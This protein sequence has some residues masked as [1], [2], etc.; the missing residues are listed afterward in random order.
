M[1]LQ[2]GHART[3]L[4]LAVAALLSLILAACGTPAPVPPAAAAQP[5]ATSTIAPAGAGKNLVVNGDAEAGPGTDGSSVAPDVPGWT[6]TGDL[7]AIAYDTASSGNY[8]TPS[9]PGPPDR[10]RNFFGGG[11]RAERSGATQTI[12]VSSEGPALDGGRESYTLSAWLG[13]FRGQDDQV[14]LTAQFLGAGG[15][16]LATASLPVVLDRDRG[17][18]TA[19]LLRTASGSVPAGTRRI[20]VDMEMIRKAGTANDGYADDVSLVL[21]PAG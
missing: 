4:T 9:D 3:T 8:P 12:D 20:K 7:T 6:R 15:E 17:G 1:S 10:G 19:L 2:H 16:V 5:T 21:D 14:E 11:P 13:G 18:R